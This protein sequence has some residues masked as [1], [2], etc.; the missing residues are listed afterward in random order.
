MEGGG[1]MRY[2]HIGKN[3]GSFKSLSGIN[4]MLL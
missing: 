4:E 1:Y 3:A 2:T